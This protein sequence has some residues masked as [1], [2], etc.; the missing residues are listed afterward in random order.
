[1]VQLDGSGSSDPD[2]NELDY[3]WTIVSA[4][5]SSVAYLSDV[6]SVNPYFIPDIAGNYEIGLVVNDGWVDSPLDQVTIISQTLQGA[7]QDINGDIFDLVNSGILTGR[8]GEKLSK[9]LD[10]V[11]D[12]LD[13]GKENSALGKL[14]SF[15]NK[16]NSMIKS[17]DYTPKEAAALQ[18]LIASA[19]RIIDNI[20]SSTS[21]KKVK[22]KSGITVELEAQDN[23]LV[24][25][26]NPFAVSVKLE[27]LAASDANM[28]LTIYSI[29][30]IKIATV[31]EGNV[32]KAK[33]Y[34]WMYEPDPEVSSGLY[35]LH[36][37]VGDTKKVM[38]L[39]YFPR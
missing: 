1:M 5:S 18:A 16:V 17:G 8:D 21:G 38:P 14:N 35:L 34:N 3:Y 15:I 4:P 2:F 24:L 12:K 13:D 9:K 11:T 19:T 20:N 31:F 36:I 25:Y 27:Y 33:S 6:F 37:V 7:I 28:S 10:D 23:P 30:G 39:M 32:E 22:S 26:P 29:S